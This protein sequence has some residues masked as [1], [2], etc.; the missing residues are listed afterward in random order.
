MAPSSQSPPEAEEAASVG[1]D[2]PRAP[3]KAQPKGQKEEESRAGALEDSSTAGPSSSSKQ[4]GEAAAGSQHKVQVLYT[5][6][7][8]HLV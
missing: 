2:Q 7:V 5:F 4:E 6:M 1:K 3:R 8:S